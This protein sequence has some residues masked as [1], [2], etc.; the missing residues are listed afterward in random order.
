MGLIIKNKK[1]LVM[2]L[3]T[4][5]LFSVSTP[6]GVKEVKASI[7]TEHYAPDGRMYM[8]YVPTSYN[9]ETPMPLMVMLHGSGQ[10][11]SDLANDS[12]INAIAE[13]EGFIVA[14]PDQPTTANGVK[15]WNWFLPAHQG[16]GMGEPASIVGVVDHIKSQ[17]NINEG[18]V[19]AQGGSAGGAMAVI[20]GVT[21]PDVFTAIGVHF[22]LEY[23]AATNTTEASYAGLY[24]GPDPITQG[25]LAYAQMGD[26]ARVVP[27]IVWQGSVDPIVKPINGNQVIA[28]M[29]QA[30][31]LAY[32]GQD[33]N[34]IDEVADESVTGYST[35]H[36]YQHY[37]Y[38][39]S[40][41]NQVIMERYLVFGMGH[42]IAGGVAG[43]FTDPDAPN[44]MEIS[45]EFLNRFTK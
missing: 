31:D 18:K 38:K 41:T 17:Y 22:G 4:L 2:M 32:D 24:G 36:K 8:L 44:S 9:P 28:Q 20:L 40:A 11:P 26:R 33:N 43:G 34:E 10:T 5:L 30:N 23:K 14:Y 15:A 35:G 3:V 25:N 12:A 37:K 6:F 19:Y 1:F 21:Y 7:F 29:A 27:T 42:A 16:R 13:R 45:W 39:N